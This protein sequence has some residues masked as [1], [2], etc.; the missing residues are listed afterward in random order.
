MPKD[1]SVFAAF[2]RSHRERVSDLLDQG[3]LLAVPQRAAV[4]EQPR[5]RVG[6]HSLDDLQ[7]VGA[8]RAAGFGVID[9]RVNFPT[10][11]AAGFDKK[12]M[13]S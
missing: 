10:L 4:D 8:Q 9:D 3:P 6:Q 11:A 1:R 12:S 5:G 2:G 13:L 7:P